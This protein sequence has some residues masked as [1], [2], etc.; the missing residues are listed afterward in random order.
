MILHVDGNSFYASCERIFRPD[1][2]GKPIAVLTNN[3]GIIISLNAEC[4]RLGFKRGD[5]YFKMKNEYAAKGVSVFSSNYTLYSDIS[6][7]M[8]LIYSYYAPETEI[9][10]IDESFLFYPD[11]KNMEWQNLGHE[12]ADTVWQQVHIPVAVGIAPTK[13][14]AKLC[15]K[16][17]K[18]HCGV[19]EWESCDKERTLSEYPVEDVWGIGPAKQQELAVHGIKTAFDLQRMPLSEAKRLLTITGFKTVQELN[20]IQCIE[21]IP[22]RKRQAIMCS[23]SFAHGVST[24]PELETA[25]ADY[26]MRAVTTMKEEGSACRTISV[27]LM[28]ARA[29]TLE[30]KEMEYFNGAAVRLDEPTSYLP[31]IQKAAE[32]LLISIYRYGYEFR[33]VMITLLELQSDKTVQL[34]LFKPDDAETKKKHDALMNTLTEINRKFGRGTLHTGV[35]NCT[36]DVTDDGKEATWHM[37]RALLSPEYTTK[38]EDIPGAGDPVS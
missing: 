16:L 29:Y 12:I 22:E 38:I 35:R 18:H 26:A 10:S 32:E 33:K 23:R 8:N 14:L 37:Q 21:R 36:P 25:L 20:G 19:F 17:A 9:Y 13:T 11:W 31:D 5:V 7:R 34:D 6:M 1:L 27:Y 15:N 30:E 3:D 2:L 4:K 24:L 28:T